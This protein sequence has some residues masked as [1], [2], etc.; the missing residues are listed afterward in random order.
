MTFFTTKKA[1]LVGK[2]FEAIQGKL[3]IVSAG[4]ASKLHVFKPEDMEVINIEAILQQFKTA[5]LKQIKRLNKSRI[6]SEEFFYRAWSIGQGS[7]ARTS[8]FFM[9]HN[10]LKYFW[11]KAEVFQAT[12]TDK[13]SFFRKHRLFSKT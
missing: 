3:V 9:G 11:L 13:N 1:R 5:I 10:V 7:A 12:P 2:L 8:Y 4:S 6:E